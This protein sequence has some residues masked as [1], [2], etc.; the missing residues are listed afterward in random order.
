MTTSFQ[1]FSQGGQFQAARVDLGSNELQ[2]L[3]QRRERELQQ[4]SA[5]LLRRDTQAARVTVRNTGSPS[6]SKYYPKI[7]SPSGAL[8]MMPEF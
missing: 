4:Q 7:Q 2:Q 1:S 8:L 3:N 5:E 6:V